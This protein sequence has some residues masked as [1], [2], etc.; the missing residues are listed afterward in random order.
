[1]RMYINGIGCVSS[2]DTK[3]KP[4][5]STIIDQE[6]LQLEI[7]KPNYKEYI[8]PV[9]S[10]RMGKVIKMGIV[11]CMD[12][13]RDA[14]IENPDAIIAGTGMG[15]QEDSEQFLEAVINDKEQFLTPTSFIQSTHNTVAGQVALM[16]KCNAYNFT[17][18]HRGFSF[19][20]ALID[21]EITLSENRSK[22]ILAFGLDEITAH[23]RKTFQ[24]IGWSVNE[25]CNPLEL[26]KSDHK[27]T[28]YGEGT[29]SFVLSENK[30]ENSYGSIEEIEM[31]YKPNQIEVENKLKEIA[32]KH[33]ID[34]VL[35]GYNGDP[36]FDKYYPNLETIFSCASIGGFKHLVGEYHTA[37]SFALWLTCMVLKDQVLPEVVQLKGPKKSSFQKILIYNHYNNLNHSFILVGK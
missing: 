15:C 20:N 35:A 28:I 7:D 36:Q 12:A 18:C 29:A 32:E 22:N 6:V 9:K 16:L 21:A 2:L 34:L 14:N 31:L 25:A 13:L 11:A 5:F 33:S 17:Y 19:E 4:L 30:T 8:S 10:R 1:M 37:S 3:T 23:S 27:G 24:R 26:L